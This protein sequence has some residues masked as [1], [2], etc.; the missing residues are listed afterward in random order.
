[1]TQFHI[2][3]VELICEER[4]FACIF[5][6]VRLLL[7]WNY[8]FYLHFLILSLISVNIQINRH[9]IY[10]GIFYWNIDTSTIILAATLFFLR[11]RILKLWP[12]VNAI[13]ISVFLFKLEF[14]FII[15][16]LSTIKMVKQ[17]VLIRV[18]KNEYLVQTKDIKEIHY[19]KRKNYPSPPPF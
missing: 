16:Y 17:Y 4:W 12:N 18:N 14:C 9:F 3:S 13:L 1:M 6:C 7:C 2:W 8:N 15:I 11:F 10:K 19:I 5:F